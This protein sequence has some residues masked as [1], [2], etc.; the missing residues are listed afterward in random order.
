MVRPA[1][2][3]SLSP[4]AQLLLLAAGPGENDDR[5]RSLVQEDQLRWPVV[6]ALA[7]NTKSTAVLVRRLDA[8]GADRLPAEV[9]ARL[10]QMGMVTDF[11]M[12]CLQDRILDVLDRLA[13]M[14]VGA[15]LLKGA[16]LATTAYGSFQARPMGDVD[17]LLAPEYAGQ[18]QQALLSRGWTERFLAEPD[19]EV[20]N[21]R[22][23]FYQGHH[24]LAPLTDTRGTGAVIEVHTDI[25]PPGAPFRLPP[26]R[27]REAARAASFEG[28]NILVPSDEHLLLHLCLHFAWS[29]EMQSGAWRTFRDLQAIVTTRDVDWDSVISA[30]E[31]ARGTTCC[32][33]TL[34]LAQNLAGIP[35]PPDVLT[36]LRPGLPEPVLRRVEYH[37]AHEL[38][39]TESICPS[40]QIRRTM[41]EVAIRPGS[42][43]HGS[44]RPWL[45]SGG[46][47]LVSSN[48]D[49]GIR[50]IVGHAQRLARWKRY[51]HAILTV[52]KSPAGLATGA[53]SA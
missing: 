47:P 15:V 41:W 8:A 1:S 50:K 11:H 16:A 4:E 24:H 53:D 48:S 38:L 29:N 37:L 34:R 25:L 43:G 19:E 20:Q 14:Q 27:I 26:W 49:K 12:A 23:E 21:L 45:A 32:Y 46:T 44:V 30:A 3:L 52:G 40:V 6:C 42:S 5:I 18:V 35:L 36:A 51:A 33:W 17:L 28:R 9:R 10:Q 2:L 39:P 31:L 13:E 22:R 7:A